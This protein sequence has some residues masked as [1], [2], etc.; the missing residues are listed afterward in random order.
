MAEEK[1][2]LVS[3]ENPKNV[4][5]S[6]EPRHSNPT[7]TK[8]PPLNLRRSL[9]DNTRN[10]VGSFSAT[11]SDQKP[12]TDFEKGDIQA[13]VAAKEKSSLDPNV[14]DFDGPNDPTMAV[15]WPSSRKWSTVAILSFL[16]LVT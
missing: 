5:A 12:A 4:E 1:A 3:P 14:V 16:T 9:D 11:S 2:D 8:D 6:D 15:N 13:E 7:S 10:G